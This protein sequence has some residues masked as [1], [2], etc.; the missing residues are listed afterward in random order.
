MGRFDFSICSLNFV[1]G[2]KKIINTNAIM[3]RIA[4]RTKDPAKSVSKKCFPIVAISVPRNADIKPPKRTT[5]VADGLCSRVTLSM[6][7]NRNCIIV[8]TEA[9]R[10]KLAKQNRKNISSEIEKM[11]RPIS[12]IE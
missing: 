10:Q 2:S 3:K 1:V 4:N 11:Q 9:P 8:A 5:A 12:M 7:A 6:A